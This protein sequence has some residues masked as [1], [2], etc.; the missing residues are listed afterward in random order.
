MNR[1]LTL[2]LVALTLAGCGATAVVDRAPSGQVVLIRCPQPDADDLHDL[3]DE[4][5]VKTVVNLRGHKPERTW[6]R[7]E[8]VGVR[9]IGAT[10]VHLRVSG[11][12]GPTPQATREFLDLV[13]DPDNWPIVMH[14]QGGIHRTG[15]M[16]GLY[17]IAV[18]GWSNEAAIEELEDNWFDWTIE[19][20]S[21]IK[22]FLR[23]YQPNRDP[24]EQAYGTAQPA[25]DAE[26]DDAPSEPQS[27]PLAPDPQPVE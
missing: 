24:E 8:E 4:Y 12:S 16:V 25:E 18:Q 11:R 13:R 27:D 15:V 21:A 6:Y 23:N 9:E 19:D 22:T 20:R 17:R 5:G 26:P 1:P 10:W 2:V 3:Q 7:D 14:C